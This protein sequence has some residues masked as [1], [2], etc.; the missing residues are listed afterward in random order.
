MARRHH[1][2]NRA[3]CETAWT[4]GGQADMEVQG[5]LPGSR[6]RPDLRLVFH[7]DHLLSDVQIN[8][9]L[10]PS[11]VSRVAGGKPMTV[12]RASA[13]LKRNKYERMRRHVGATFIPFV[14][15]SFGGL[16]DDAL[17]LVGRMADAAQQHMQMWQRDQIVRHVLCNVAVA[18]QRENAATVLAG[19]AAIDFSRRG[20]NKSDDEGATDEDEQEDEDEEEAEDNEEDNEQ[21][22]ND[23]DVEQAEEEDEKQAEEQ[24][25]MEA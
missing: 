23:Q 10:A 14:A 22:L 12:A 19:H 6:L 17:Q 24:Y 2:V 13:R 20:T 1:A 18:I 8:H 16:S 11:Y 3:L 25:Q 15:D 7:G 5:L 9:P 4:L 21:K